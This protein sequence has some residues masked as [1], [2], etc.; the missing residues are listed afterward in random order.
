MIGG[1]PRLKKAIQLSNLKRNQSMKINKPNKKLIKIKLKG[2][3]V[4]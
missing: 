2:I 3:E 1:P 4:N